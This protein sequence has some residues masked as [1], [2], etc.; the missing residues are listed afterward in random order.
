M[1]KHIKF[2]KILL[3]LII[4]NIIIGMILGFLWYK[5]G[6]VKLIINMSSGTDTIK[7]IFI[8]NKTIYIL[9]IFF[10]ELSNI[11]IFQHLFNTKKDCLN[12][13]I[14]SIIISFLL[15]LISIFG[16][17]TGSKIITLGRIE[18]IY[19]FISCVGL[20]YNSWLLTLN[21]TTL[22]GLIYISKKKKHVVK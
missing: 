6:Y 13:Y 5:V 19:I 17:S 11:I 8:Y 10:I 18:D 3:L 16:F 1:N 22:L 4:N 20:R 14:L 15:L 9:I 21:I 12:Y 2:L 7:T